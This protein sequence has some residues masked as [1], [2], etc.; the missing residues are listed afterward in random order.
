MFDFIGI[1]NGLINVVLLLVILVVLV[2]L[3]EFGHFIVARKAGVK[4]H[5]FGIGFP[6]RA[7]VLGSDGETTYTLNWLPIGGF[8]KLEGEEGDS[9]DPRSFV[10]QRLAT[11]VT[12]LLAGVA[13]NILIAFLIFTAIAGLADPVADVRIAQVQPD[14]PA[15]SI[16]LIGQCPDGH[17]RA[18]QPGLRRQRRLDHRHRR[19]ALPHLRSPRS[20]GPVTRLPA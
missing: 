18:G 14:S 8:V 16:G 4:V 7:R 9:D 12:I 11:R 2:V 3:H 20:A 10:R 19:P 5:E 15:A 6:P 17:R 13:M 1:G